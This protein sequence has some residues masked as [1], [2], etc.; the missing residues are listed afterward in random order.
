MRSAG[1]APPPAATT[2]RVRY[3][4]AGA[5]GVRHAEVTVVPGY[6]QESDIPAILAARLT[7]PPADGWRIVLLDVVEA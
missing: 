3:A 6:S 5:P 4:L 1:P 7:G 2:Y